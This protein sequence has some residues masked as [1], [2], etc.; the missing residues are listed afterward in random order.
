MYK[1][2][3]WLVYDQDVCIGSVYGATEAEA[4][5]DAVRKYGFTT[6]KC[7]VF[8]QPLGAR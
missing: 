7:P 5:Q 3:E 1:V 4:W 2:Q 6:D 8:L